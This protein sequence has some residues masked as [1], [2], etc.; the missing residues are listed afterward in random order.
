MVYN[1]SLNSYLVRLLILYNKICVLHA[2][3][4]TSSY[5]D[6]IQD[7]RQYMYVNTR[8]LTIFIMFQIH[9]KNSVVMYCNCRH[10]AL[11]HIV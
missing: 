7:Q 3:L 10:R 9:Q 8:S 5:G 11:Q 4:H 6:A 2:Q 1:L